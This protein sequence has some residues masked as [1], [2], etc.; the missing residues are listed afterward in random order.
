MQRLFLDTNVFII[1]TV[2]PGSP[3]ADILEW[4]GFFARRVGRPTVV[5]SDALTEQLLRVGRRVG[6]KDYGGELIARL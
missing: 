2:I 6:G 4:P 3:E 1:G 5:V